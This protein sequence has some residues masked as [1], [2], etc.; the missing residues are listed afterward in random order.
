MPFYWAYLCRGQFYVF[1]AFLAAR[2]SEQ[3]PPRNLFKKFSS[4]HVLSS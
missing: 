1:K 2:V 3:T 4:P